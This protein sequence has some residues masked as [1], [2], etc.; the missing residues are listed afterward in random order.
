M[1]TL[2]A[3]FLFAFS[4]GVLHPQVLQQ[5]VRLAVQRNMAPAGINS[6]VVE[7]FEGE[8]FP[9]A[10]WVIDF[11]G[12]Q[13]WK[14]FVGASGYGA[15]SASAKFDIYLAPNGT[16]Q[17]LVL[18]SMG[19]SLPG[20]SL[21]FDHAYASWTG[22]VDRL[23]IQTSTNGGATYTTLVILDGGVSGPLATAP[24]QTT[25]FV[26]AA[27]QWATK[28]YALPVGTNRVR[29]AA[30][31]AY[32]NN[33]YLDNVNIG[34]QPGNDVAVMS[35]DVPTPTRTLPQVP[36]ATVKN[37]GTA[38]KT[39][40][41]SM[42][43]SPGGYASARTVS[44]L[45]GNATS[46][47]SFDGW[48]PTAG[49]ND[50][51]VFVT[52]AGDMDHTND[53]LR[54]AIPA[55]PVQPVTNIR[56]FFRDGQVFITW[57][58]LTS[59]NLLYTVYR[60]P[61]PIQHG[62]QLGSAQCLGNVRDNSGLDARMSQIT[63][64][65]WYLRIDPDSVPLTINKGLFVATSSAGGSFWYAVTTSFN[66]VEDTSIAPGSNSLAFAVTEKIMAPKPVWQASR[67]VGGRTYDI[68]AQFTTKETT[69]V[70]PRMTN[71]G[72]YPFHFAVVKS[73]AVEPHPV[74]FSL[75]GMGGNFLGA[76]SFT[77]IGNPN[78][79]VVTIDDWLPNDD[80]VTHFYG[81]HEDYDIYS[82][83]N[84]IPESGVLYNYTS[85][86]IAHTIDWTI[87][88]LPVD[89]T[90]V[91]L[92]G[93]SMGGAGTLING[94]VLP[95]KI[96][97]LIAYVPRMEVSW[98]GWQIWGLPE[99]NLLTNEG[100]RRNERLNATYL[101]RLHRSTYLP[102][103]FTFCGKTDVS[104]GWDDKVPFYDS[105]NTYRLG[106]FHFWSM[107]NHGGTVYSSPWQPSFPDFSA[108]TRYRTS[109]SYP[110]FSYCSLNGNPGDGDPANGD[111][112]GTINGHLD[113]NDDIVDTTDRWE[114]TLR[115]KDLATTSGTLVA[116]DSGVTD[117]TL[118]RLQ[119]FTVP[120]GARLV[121]KNQKGS[122]VIQKDSSKYGGGLITIPAFKVF[123]ASS[124]LMVSWHLIDG[125]ADAYTVPS[126][127]RLEQNYPNPLNPSTTIKFE[128]P[129]A[130]MVRLSVFDMLGREVSVLVNER[131]DA[132]VHEVKFDGSNLAS[133]VYFYR[134]KAG[135]FVQSRKLL[136]LK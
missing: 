51:T 85:A 16:T 96:A 21:R 113:W 33:L 34:V 30:V 71:A 7:D 125:I 108:V 32:G 14:R 121:W 53:T 81:Y 109:L 89:S 97:A 102:V 90:R 110:A 78:A 8:R 17:S 82:S 120:T 88:N 49:I 86:R 45:A 118:R 132:G 40:T 5:S 59:N 93:I 13:F 47:V 87:R 31:S 36:K 106:G 50:V 37:I 22:E 2:V 3:V 122:E 83:A 94:F 61:E 79:W 114:I 29:F 73:G 77:V 129:K 4:A 95:T 91:Y 107:T 46:Q 60:Y 25:A 116:P 84:P 69:S 117:V 11:T 119:E 67:V 6:V 12:R 135:D 28:S 80:N 75:H 42:L 65:S 104:V 62:H 23:T 48:T 58:N 130:S 70:Y 20:D 103:L 99:T 54:T 52:F 111:P 128:L 92:T 1:R 66:G 98:T 127:Y 74:I 39:F 27:A 24:P 9:P 76:L 18:S 124:R 55:N 19:A 43:I 115:V 101:A 136:L 126:Q 68:Y 63:G 123:K 35:I 44:G 133:G 57:D 72:S 131:R 41:V 105:L 134:M 100:L 38:T 64:G 15:G 10:G 56:A 112:M 26:P